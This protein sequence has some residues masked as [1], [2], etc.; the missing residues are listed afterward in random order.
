MTSKDDKKKRLPGQLRDDDPTVFD[1]EKILD[2]RFNLDHD[3][4]RTEYFVKWRR[5]NHKKNTWEP[6]ENLFD[7]RLLQKWHR[8][9]QNQSKLSL[10]ST[11]NGRV[12][13]N[14]DYFAMLA[15]TKILSVKNDIMITDV[16]VNGVVCTIRESPTP[17]AF[18]ESYM[19]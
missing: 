9:K 7:G 19:K 5:Y 13:E 2:E 18:F 6:A 3:P 12:S 14:S 15:L 1:A 16:E 8:E 17:E 11:Q 10:K 4:P